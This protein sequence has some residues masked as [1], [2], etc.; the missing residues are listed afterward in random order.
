MIEEYAYN[1]KELIKL[2]LSAT[3]EDISAKTI[4][5][6]LHHTVYRTEQTGTHSNFII[7]GE[8]SNYKHINDIKASN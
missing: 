7:Y 8:M 5:I 3:G 6:W 1:N 4:P 2:G